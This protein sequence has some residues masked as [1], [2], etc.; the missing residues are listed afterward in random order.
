MGWLVRRT[1]CLEASLLKS[2]TN[3]TASPPTHRERICSRCIL[4]S[5]SRTALIIA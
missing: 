1:L 4:G 2:S 3:G 5:T